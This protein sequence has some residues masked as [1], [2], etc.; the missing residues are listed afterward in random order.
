MARQDVEAPGQNYDFSSFDDKALRRG[1]IR[2]VFAILCAQLTL[3]TGE[4]SVEFTEANTFKIS[5]ELGV[6]MVKVCPTG[7]E[8]YAASRE[9][10][11]RLLYRTRKVSLQ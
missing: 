10:V 6:I 1:F 3:V 7:R 5:D 8:S 9:A 2:K 4:C 11:A